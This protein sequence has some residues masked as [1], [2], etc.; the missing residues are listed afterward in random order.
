M[1]IVDAQAF[2][3]HT[4]PELRPSIIILDVGNGEILSDPAIAQAR[5]RLGARRR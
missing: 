5:A 1:H 3:H 2:L 4:A